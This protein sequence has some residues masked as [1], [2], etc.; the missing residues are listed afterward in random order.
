MMSDQV[1]DTID[2]IPDDQP[3]EPDGDDSIPPDERE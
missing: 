2:H 1:Y 3:T